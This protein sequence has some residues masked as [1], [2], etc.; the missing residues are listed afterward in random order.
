MPELHS[1]DVVR[2]RVCLAGDPRDVGRIDVKELGVLVDEAPDQPRAR[3]AVDG[4][5]LA[6]HES[7]S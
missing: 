3:D 6:G 5:V 7:H 4:G 2:D 1:V